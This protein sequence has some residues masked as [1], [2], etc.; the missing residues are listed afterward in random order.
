MG[1]CRVYIEANLHNLKRITVGLL[2][3]GSYAIRRNINVRVA[4]IQFTGSGQK[5]CIGH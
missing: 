3:G 4:N 2:Y 5:A 1:K